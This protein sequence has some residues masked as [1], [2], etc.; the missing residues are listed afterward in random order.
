VLRFSNG[1]VIDVDEGGLLIGREPT[2]RSSDI[3]TLRLHPLAD[4]AVSKSHVVIGGTNDGLWI[5]DRDS[6]NGTSVIDATGAL[7]EAPAA[8][9][10]ALALPVQILLG[11]TTIRADWSDR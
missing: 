6:T 4:P 9:R 2:R 1:D 3:D 7:I 10:V 8:T 11:D 5:E